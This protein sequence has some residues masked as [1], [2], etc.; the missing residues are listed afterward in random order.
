MVSHLLEEG[1]LA[2]AGVALDAVE[3]LAKQ[4]RQ[5][6][7]LWAA[8]ALRGLRLLLEGRFEEAEKQSHE[9]LAM[10]Q[11]TGNQNALFIFGAQI[12]TTRMEQGRLSSSSRPW[13]SPSSTRSFRSGD[14]PSPGFKP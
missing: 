14:A 12:Y 5:S 2:R 3:E 9:A 6:Y 1:A 7:Y 4:S 11:R 10:G 8:A 13:A